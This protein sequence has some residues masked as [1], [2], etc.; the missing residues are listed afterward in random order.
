MNKKWILIT[1]VC[2]IVLASALMVLK[3]TGSTGQQ[4]PLSAQ[5]N[6][7]SRI[8][9]LS[10]AS[11][12]IL[13]ALGAGDLVAART[14]FCNYPA[15][16][17]NCPSVGG[18]DGKTFSLETVLAFAPD[19]V[20][21]NTAMHG[22]LVQSLTELG[23]EIF[24]SDAQSIPDIYTEI[25]QVG[26]IT[27]KEKNAEKLVESMKKRIDKPS[28]ANIISVYW[29]VWNAP[30]M[31]I[32]NTSFINEIIQ[33]SGAQ[34]IFNDLSA[35]YP[36]VS[37]ES[38]IARNPS[39]ILLPSDSPETLDTIKNRSGWDSIDAVNNNRVYKIDGDI[40]SRPGPRLA[41]AIEAIR[42]CISQ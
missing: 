11:T 26:V 14:D 13:F 41:E 1:G 24:A 2:A 6:T 28:P 15:E 40:I 25:L 9:S 29:E 33:A 23:I 20:Y 27:G 8:V 38:I 34:N 3:C 37:E 35:S 42:A 19:L 4:N 7:P 10:P 32:G 36:V 16:A 5:E 31:S 22:H 18:F 39:V 30:Y 12:E 21:L 17:Q